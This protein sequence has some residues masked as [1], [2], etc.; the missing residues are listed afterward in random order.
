MEQD[1]SPRS[2][3]V[4]SNML[5]RF[6]ERL[7]A[8]LVAFLVSII[9]AR[10]LEPSAYGTV[11]LI[12]VFTSLLQVFVDSGLGN[13]LIQKKDADDI[14]FSTVFFTNIVFCLF[15]Y[16]VV[17]FLSSLIA[18]FYNNIT[19]I[20]YIR[21][22]GL[23]ILISG[24]KN[25]Q[26]AY[27]SR[28]LLFRKFFFSTLG[29]TIIAGI[30]GIIMAYNG[31]GVWA[32]IAQQ[33][34]NVSI[35]TLILWL[36]VKWRPIK[37]FSWKRLKKLFSYGWKL[38]ASAFLDTSYKEI[39][40]LV[41]GKKYSSEDLAFYN[42][43]EKFPNLIIGN[44]NTSIDSVLLPVM[45]NE[46]NDR[47]RVKMMTRR[48]IQISTYIMAP[49]MLGL[50]F[51]GEPVIKVLLTEKW[52]SAVFYMR[53]FCISYMFYPIHTANLN[54]IKA[55]GRSDLFLKLEIIKKVIGL[56]LLLITMNISVEAMAYS[57]LFTTITSQII[58][59]WPN[60]K[61]LGYSYL[62]Q[63]MDIIPNITLAVFMGVC[64]YFIQYIHISNVIAILLQL[65]IGASIYIICSKL[66]KIDS[67]LYVLDIVKSYRKHKE[68]H[69]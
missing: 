45:S 65:S 18:R 13:A 43:G 60:R 34:I 12:S 63:I 59:S 27:V 69:K 56:V 24:L 50:A 15:L 35:D 5:W 52:L 17:F 33:V 36:T 58:N 39:R 54:A 4:T 6:G 53:V 46:Q 23:T 67:F 26:Q 22:L 2:K 55:M 42:Q 31:F 20:P 16:I 38:L 21:V 14:D 3:A 41:I 49:L 9:L 48:S 62:E 64:I 1:S 47:E 7:L 19:L 44:I 37:A 51:I 57:L 8:Q 61:L 10:I 40:Q 29:G 66:F 30:L 25:V 11:A 32:L 28:H 68:E